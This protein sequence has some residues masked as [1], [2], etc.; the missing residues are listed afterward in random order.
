MD[1]TTQRIMMTAGAAEE[2]GGED[3]YTGL[4]GS[5]QTNR[6]YTWT[7]PAGVTSVSVVCIGGGGEGGDH[8]PSPGTGGGGG[9]A[10]RYA[11]NVSVTPGQNYEVQVGCS[12]NNNSG[13]TSWF[14]LNSSNTLCQAEGGGRGTN[15]IG[16]PGGP[17]G[18]SGVG[19]GGGDGGPGGKGNNG[20]GGG[21]GG[22]AGG[23]SGNGSPGGVLYSYNPNATYNYPPQ[24]SGGA[25][26]G[27]ASGWG[28]Y[29]GSG[30][31]VYPFGQGPN[32]AQSSSSNKQGGV[33]SFDSNT[34]GPIGIQSHSS[35]S[36]VFGGGGMGTVWG[37]GYVG[38]SG[39]VRIIYPG[40]T[41]Q[42]PSTNTEYQS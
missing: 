38:G 27:G 23:Y 21:G 39:C 13:G 20:G 30:G 42:F 35:R 3:L 15:N 14:R 7:C 26:S 34:Y 25:G 36:T 41:R 37:S 28:N 9:G 24:G 16:G 10:L 5:D 2:A 18:N 22:G 19:N 8:G 17:G 11:N 4:S 6:S 40:T 32:G 31:G 12:R 33:G 1:P 29:G